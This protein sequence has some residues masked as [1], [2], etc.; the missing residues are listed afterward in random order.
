MDALS[1]YY[2][3]QNSNVHRGAHCLSR[4]A[5]LA[6]EEARDSVARFVNAYSRNERNR[7]HIRSYGSHQPGCQQLRT[8]KYSERR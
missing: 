1:N 6:Y 7:L 4:E 3:T 8:T 2:M 5:T